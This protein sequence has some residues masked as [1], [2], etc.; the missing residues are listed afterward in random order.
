[1]PVVA[2]H[3]KECLSF[4]HATHEKRRRELQTSAAN[5]QYESLTSRYS[6]DD[7]KMF[8]RLHPFQRATHRRLVIIF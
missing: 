2:F 8:H 3:G 7:R 6:L 1:M 5:T 4:T